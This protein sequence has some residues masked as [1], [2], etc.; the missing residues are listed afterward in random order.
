M[1][2]A[3]VSKYINKDLLNKIRVS[4]DFSKEM[5]FDANLILPDGNIVR[6]PL[7]NMYFIRT[8]LTTLP[9]FYI[10]N[11][12][13]RFTVNG[14]RVEIPTGLDMIDNL[15]I[16]VLNFIR[17]FTKGVN[18][19]FTGVSDTDL[20]EAYKIMNFIKYTYK[21]FDRFLLPEFTARFPKLLGVV[22]VEKIKIDGNR[23]TIFE[24]INS[25]KRKELFIILNNKLMI[26][27][28][29][30]FAEAFEDYGANLLMKL[31]V[32]IKYI[33]D[34]RI[35]VSL[36]LRDGK[37]EIVVY[38]SS[39]RVKELIN[40]AD[41]TY[42]FINKKTGKVVIYAD[43]VIFSTEMSPSIIY[44]MKQ[45]KFRYSTKDADI[46]EYLIKANG[47]VKRI[48]VIEVEKTITFPLIKNIIEDMHEVS[49]IRTI[50]S[51]TYYTI[52]EGLEGMKN[53]IVSFFARKFKLNEFV[54]E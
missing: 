37:D 35:R 51:K 50:G 26:E 16:E 19:T 13:V 27:A 11:C 8:N 10:D 24:R 17:K 48:F 9:L 20:Y 5:A 30:R 21:D 52:S 34:N 28:D 22:K 45:S 25:D 44:I 1:T 12:I 38:A 47:E 42:I 3:S 7:V 46:R 32:I 54:N 31:D 2:K 14:K 41:E 33:N 39:V 15:P 18:V 6:V 29:E 23:Y 43:S 53:S 49:I 36:I 40:D 4:Y